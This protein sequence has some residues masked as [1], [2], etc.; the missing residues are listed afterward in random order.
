MRFED[1][2][3]RSEEPGKGASAFSVGGGETVLVFIPHP[4]GVILRTSR[5]SFD[6]REVA[7]L[8][9][10]AAAHVTEYACSAGEGAMGS[11]HLVVDC[12]AT[13]PTVSASHPGFPGGTHVVQIS[14]EQQDRIN[15]LLQAS[16]KGRGVRELVGA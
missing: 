3:R 5:W 2:R 6:A 12:G 9:F 15:A 7:L 10:D 14:H 16:G 11:L 8:H 1:G 4:R 13:I